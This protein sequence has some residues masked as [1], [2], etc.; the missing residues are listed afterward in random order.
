MKLSSTIVSCFP[1]VKLAVFHEYF[2]ALGYFI[3]FLIALCYTAQNGLSVYSSIWLAGKLNLGKPQTPVIQKKN[4]NFFAVHT[5][6][7]SCSMYVNHKKC[8]LSFDAYKLELN[9]VKCSWNSAICEARLT[10]GLR[11][12]YWTGGRA[13]IT[14]CVRLQ[15]HS[16]ILR[17][18]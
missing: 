7:Q 9:R 4:L 13:K 12:W 15:F 8:C 16:N 17:V 5:I 10:L 14:D 18:V 1:Q 2:K 3:V 6:N 11:Q